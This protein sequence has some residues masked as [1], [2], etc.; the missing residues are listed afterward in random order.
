MVELLSQLSR[1]APRLA[2]DRERGASLV[3]YVLLVGL[4]A[5]ACVLALT[6]FGTS[7][8]QSLSHS[9][10]SITHAG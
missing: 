10:S 8:S 1:R 3:E 6:I 9:G 7:L 5:L 2:A 4:I